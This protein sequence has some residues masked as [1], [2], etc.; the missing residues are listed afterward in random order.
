MQRA[1]VPF[2]IWT[3]GKES[4]NQTAHGIM[5][6]QKSNYTTISILTRGEC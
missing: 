4:H 1:R 3:D 5:W 2:P 6:Q